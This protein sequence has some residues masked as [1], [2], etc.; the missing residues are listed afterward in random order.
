[1]R[2]ATVGVVD[3]ST[4]GTPVKN[5]PRW[6]RRVAP[7]AQPIAPPVTPVIGFLA[8]GTVFGRFL[9]IWFGSEHASL[10]ASPDWEY[11]ARPLVYYLS[12][13]T[14]VDVP[15]AATTVDQPPSDTSGYGSILMRR[16]S[17]KG[18]RLIVSRVTNLDNNPTQVM[19]F[20]VDT[21][22]NGSIRSGVVGNGI[23]QMTLEMGAC[24]NMY[25][26]RERVKAD[27]MTHWLHRSIMQIG[28]MKTHSPGAGLVTLDSTALD[29][30]QLPWVMKKSKW[31]VVCSKRATKYCQQC[32]SVYYCTRVCQRA[33]WKSTHRAVCHV[34]QNATATSASGGV[35][36]S[37]K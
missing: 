27:D 20:Q 8:G 21:K 2:A 30:D 5:V 12:D 36:I 13:G 10:L 1:M 31:C 28:D 32:G 23:H 7:P 19:F 4:G 37:R 6:Y 18:Y 14:T 24:A 26:P 34:P 15:F 25:T 17:N 33:H 9:S 35:F 16:P 22:L 3:W 11:L 29:V